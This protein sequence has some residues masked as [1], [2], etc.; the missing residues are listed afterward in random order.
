MTQFPLITRLGLR[1]ETVQ[2]DAEPRN[3]RDNWQV[4]RADEL[5]K[6]LA[7]APVVYAT[8]LHL[9]K[10]TCPAVYGWND[11]NGPNRT[12]TALLVGITPLKVDTAES[13]LRELIEYNGGVW[14]DSFWDRARRL[15]G[16]K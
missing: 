13:L 14:P 8:D 9:P 11:I 15:L 7:S 10:G 16:E 4:V 5:E 6:M 3:Y 1:I 2:A 12:H